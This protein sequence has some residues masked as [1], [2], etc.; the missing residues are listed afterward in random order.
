MTY[1]YELWTGYSGTQQNHVVTFDGLNSVA[2]C[3][4]EAM[5]RKVADAL[6]QDNAAIRAEALKD[7]EDI[8]CALWP[9]QDAIRAAILAGEVK[10]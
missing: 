10:E 1:R 8:V 2:I 6:N 5:A 7:A 4:N 3:D 9:D